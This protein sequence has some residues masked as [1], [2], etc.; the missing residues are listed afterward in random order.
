MDGVGTDTHESMPSRPA[1]N[2]S[3]PETSACDADGHRLRYE[4]ET[5]NRCRT[6]WIEY[7]QKLCEQHESKQLKCRVS[8]DE[9]R[10]FQ[11][12]RVEDVTKTMHVVKALRAET[13]AVMGDSDGDITDLMVTVRGWRLTRRHPHRRLWIAGEEGHSAS[14]TCPL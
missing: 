1:H 5:R 11:P 3:H 4:L 2:T 14:S 7:R 6:C 12:G 8:I 13:A 10:V 9:G